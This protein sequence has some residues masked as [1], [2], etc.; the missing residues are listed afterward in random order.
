VPEF[1]T[2]ARPMVYSG[3]VIVATEDLEVALP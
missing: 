3:E 2:I 1:G